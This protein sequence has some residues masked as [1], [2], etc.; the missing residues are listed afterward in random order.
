MPARSLPMTEIGGKAV[1]RLMCGT[2]MFFGH[3]HF[4]AARSKWLVR[5][6]TMDRIV[7]VMHA[8]VE[9]GINCTV[10]GTIPQMPEAI[11]RV[12]K[13]TGVKMVWF[14]TPGGNDFEE[15]KAGIRQSQEWGA[16]FCMP[17][18]SWTDSHLLVAE[19]QIVHAEETFALIRELGMGT[20]WSTHRPETIVVTDQAGYDCD[21]YIQPF[22]SIGFLCSVETDWVASI[23]R[24]AQ[25]P[26]ISIKP[27]ASGRIMPPTG[28]PF[29]YEN[30]KPVDTVAIGCL[31]PEEVEEDAKI[32]RNLLMG[33]E[34]EI[35]LQKTRSKAALAGS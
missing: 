15:L 14:A 34:E 23:I 19:R 31:S 2:N 32:V 12:R 9:E 13:L 6:F 24:N 16:D 21:C 25:K 10:S 26:V 33:M 11:E 18:T 27:L 3:S 1:S 17:H 30:I 7:E 5:H 22:N 28:F 29:V 8:A 20:G 4:S 35:E